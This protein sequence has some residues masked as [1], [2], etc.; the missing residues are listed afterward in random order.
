MKKIAGWLTLLT[1]LTGCYCVTD[2]ED[3]YNIPDYF[4]GCWD[5]FSANRRDN[6]VNNQ[7]K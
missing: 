7:E 1:M 2:E 4:S 3:T 5:K 6:H